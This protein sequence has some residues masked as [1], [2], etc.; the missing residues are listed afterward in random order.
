MHCTFC[1]RSICRF[2]IVSSFDKNTLGEVHAI[3]T[4]G[5][6]IRVESLTGILMTSAGIE[7]VDLKQDIASVKYDKV[8]DVDFMDVTQQ[9]PGRKKAPCISKFPNSNSS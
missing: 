9:A 2:P 3:A 6:E 1:S 7:S 8:L 5:N 4:V